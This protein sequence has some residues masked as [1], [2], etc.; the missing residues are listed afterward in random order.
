[1][2]LRGHC[3]R[4]AVVGKY[5]CSMA[6]KRGTNGIAMSSCLLYP[7]TIVFQGS[8]FFYLSRSLGVGAVKDSVS[9]TFKEREFDLIVGGLKS[10]PCRLL[11]TNLD[12]EIIPYMSKFIVKQNKVI[13]KL[14]KVL[15]GDDGKAAAC[16][17]NLAAHVYFNSLQ[18]KDGISYDYWTN[19]TQKHPKV[20]MMR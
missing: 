18:M 13:V 14:K 10:G 1:M 11:K 9:C 20:W 15:Y 16:T 8:P 17:L 7:E 5:K 3:G 4:S 19:L 6:E 12:K 2:Y